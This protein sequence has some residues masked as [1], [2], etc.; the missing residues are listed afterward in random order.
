MKSTFKFLILTSIVFANYACKKKV[1]APSN[2]AEGKNIV[3]VEVYN[4][5]HLFRKPRLFFNSKTQ[6]AEITNGLYNGEPRWSYMERDSSLSGYKRYFFDI[7]IDTPRDI[8][9]GGFNLD[10]WFK[11]TKSDIIIRSINKNRDITIYDSEGKHK[12]F[13]TIGVNKF[14]VN[15]IRTD[16]DGKTFMNFEA[17]LHCVEEGN[18]SNEIDSY[19]KG[20]ILI[21][22]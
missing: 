18:P 5:K 12:S 4:Q 10:L 13:Y 22:D 9:L 14:K 16:E 19:W 21:N 7:Q 8:F 11:D 20:D 3:Y 1:V 2:E 6:M 17:D 15:D